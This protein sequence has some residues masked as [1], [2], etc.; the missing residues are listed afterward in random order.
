MSRVLFKIGTNVISNRA[1]R[2][3]RPVSR[4]LL[5]R[6]DNMVVEGKAVGTMVRRVADVGASV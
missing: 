3:L 5:R 4:K 2:I 1:N 6:R